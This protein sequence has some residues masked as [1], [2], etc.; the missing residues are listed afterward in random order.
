MRS[1]LDLLPTD[2]REAF[3][4]TEILN[5][6][7]LEAARVTAFTWAAQPGSVCL[8]LNRKYFDEAAAN[9]NIVAIVA[10]KAAVSGPPA[11]KAVIVAEQADELFYAIHNSA[12][13]E[14][15]GAKPVAGTIHPEARI[16][17]SASIGPE[18]SIGANT[19]VREGCLLIGPMD[20]G[21]D[22]VLMPG[23]MLGT[24]GMFSKKILGKKHHVRH[25]GGVKIGRN[26]IVHAGSN[27]S[28]SVNY[29][30]YT[31]LGDDV[32]IGIG[33]NVGHDST[34]GDR[35]ELSGRV[36]LAGR[37]NL[38]TDCWVGAAAVI[39]NAITVGDRAKIRIGAVVIEDVP[40]GADVSGNFAADH[41]ARLRAM[42]LAKRK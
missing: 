21:P 15:S 7:R 26:T 16:A 6:E 4:V 29:G 12:I 9:P 2:Y 40:A 25:F 18:V 33:V 41:S 17:R 30:E 13:H 42:M 8:G 39:S 35:S 1:F 34:V 24:D 20:I 3:G 36:M 5:P 28:R 37:V 19:E 32:N 14:R 10:P 22:C 31:T 27:V 23:V 11:G 38:G